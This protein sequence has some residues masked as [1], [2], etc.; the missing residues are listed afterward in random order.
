MLSYLYMTAHLLIRSLNLHTCCQTHQLLLV[1]SYNYNCKVIRWL[2]MKEYLCDERTLHIYI[3]HFVWSNIFTLLQFE[4]IFLSINYLKV[5][6][7]R[8]N[9]T[10][11]TCLQPSI[12]CD[13]IFGHFLHF[14]ITQKYLRTSNP[15]LSPRRR[16]TIFIQIQRCIF[17]FRN[18][19]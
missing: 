17:H 15:N 16:L 4:N 2:S 3:F 12:L 7:I 19:T 5:K 11:V 18:I 14:V 8:Q 9:L 6:I 13:G 10:N 1:W